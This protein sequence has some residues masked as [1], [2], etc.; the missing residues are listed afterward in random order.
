MPKPGIT[1]TLPVGCGYIDPAV[2]AG[3]ALPRG[4]VLFGMARDV[5]HDVCRTTG[6]NWSIQNG[7]LQ[8]ISPTGYLPN[9][10]V[11]INR[12]T[13]MVGL[14][15]VA[16][17]GIYV[18]CLLNPLIKV[19]QRVKLDNDSIQQQRMT[20]AVGGFEDPKFG[21]LPKVEGDGIYKVLAIDH[22]GDTRGKEWYSEICCIAASQGGTKASLGR[23]WEHPS[24]S[25]RSRQPR[26]S[27]AR[28]RADPSAS[29]SACAG[30][31]GSTSPW[32]TRG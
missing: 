17:D 18:R 23:G 3:P 10:A 11:V 16:P 24:T 7:R 12:E 6:T 5:L 25:R 22:F 21:L 15:A 27:A 9:E 30:A 19:N 28:G 4:R 13:G 2:D 31:A 14:P 29:G 32:V 8:V 26:R 1:L 20:P